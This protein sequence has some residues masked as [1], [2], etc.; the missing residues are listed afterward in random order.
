MPTKPKPRRAALAAPISP[1]ALKKRAA[2]LVE[3]TRPGNSDTPRA[4]FLARDLLA[5]LSRPA[6]KAAPMSDEILER[7]PA[8]LAKRPVKLRPLQHLERDLV[9]AAQA[10]AET[11]PAATGRQADL[12]LGLLRLAMELAAGRQAAE[13]DL[14]A[15]LAYWRPVEQ[16]AGQLADR[17]LEL[18]DPNTLADEIATQAADLAELVER[19]RESAHRLVGLPPPPPPAGK[20]AGR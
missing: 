16:A 9:A 10:I 3:L 13:N 5:A 20:E 1:A 2:L 19:T 8:F 15:L 12:A 4:H 14:R 6:A 17:A 18:A 11:A 7:A